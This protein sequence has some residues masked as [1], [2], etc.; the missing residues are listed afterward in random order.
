M[1]IRI[2]QAAALISCLI[3]VACGGSASPPP[4]DPIVARGERVFK[5]QCAACHSLKK[6]VT[7]FGPSMSGIATRA[8][9]RMEGVDSEEYIQLSIIKPSEFIV[10][11]FV[12]QM[13]ANF[14]TFLTEEELEGIIA[15]LLTLD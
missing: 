3:L 15:Y 5:S 13:P 14:G 4:S 10:D 1:G 7:I 12:D 8:S 6:G 11:G 2:L 9:T